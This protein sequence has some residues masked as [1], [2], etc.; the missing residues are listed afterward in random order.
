MDS[1]EVRRLIE[2][3]FHRGFQ[4]QVI[5]DFLNNRHGVT[6]SLSTLKRRLRYYG[7]SRR[8]VDVSDHEVRDIVQRVFHI[9]YFP[10][11]DVII[12]VMSIQLIALLL[13]CPL[14]SFALTSTSFKDLPFL[15]EI[16]GGFIN[17]F[18]SKGWFWEAK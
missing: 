14:Q 5:V 12:D 9:S 3:Y 13:C 1:R 8:G 2:H 16:R 6:M 11:H 15:Y 18:L 17:I 10:L 7:L 4:N